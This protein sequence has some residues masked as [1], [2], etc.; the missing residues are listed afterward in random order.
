ML[1]KLLVFA[2]L[3]FILNSCK[4]VSVK[5]KQFQA[6]TEK[7]GLGTIGYGENYLLENTYEHLGMVENNQGIKLHVTPV[8]FNNLN[9]KKFQAAKKVQDHNKT[10]KVADSLIEGTKF[11]DIETADKIGLIA[12]LNDE[13][14][15]KTKTFLVDTDKNHIVTSVAMVFQEDEMSAI[16]ES[17]EVFL[18]TYGVQS[19]ALQT[20][21]NGVKAS[22]IPIKEGITFAYRASSLCWKEDNKYHLQIVD[23]VAGNNHCPKKSYRSAQRAKKK[24]DYFK[25]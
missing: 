10:L 22:T 21:K 7:V 4:T 9:F 19:Y 15:K 5:N 23:L 20:Y 18:E 6:T 11:F 25:L 16:L 8:T 1:Q 12:I 13:S 3:L 2:G 14:N 24:I 17:D